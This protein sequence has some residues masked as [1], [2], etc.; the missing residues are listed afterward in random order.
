MSRRLVATLGLVVIAASVLAGCCGTC[1]K[2]PP[3]KPTCG[4][5]APAAK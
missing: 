5:A 3:C 4:C 2:D 1:I